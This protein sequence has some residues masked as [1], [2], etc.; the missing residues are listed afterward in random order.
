MIMSACVPEIVCWL[1][2]VEGLAC[3]DPR[4]RPPE[5]DLVP[6]IPSKALKCACQTL[7]LFG[8]CIQNKARKH[9][10]LLNMY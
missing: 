7:R 6:A 8:L 4:A 2:L 10:P 3:A 1:R 5:V 9:I